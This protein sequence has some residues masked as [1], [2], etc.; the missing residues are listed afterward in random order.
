MILSDGEVRATP[1]ETVWKRY[2]TVLV[3]DGGGKMQ[4][5]EEPKADWARHSYRVLNL[6]DNQ[7]R[8]L[9]QRQ[10][11]DLFQAKPARR[12][13]VTAPIGAFAPTSPITSSPTR[14]HARWTGLKELAAIPT[15]LKRL[16]DTLQE[17][18]INWATRCATP[19][20]AATSNRNFRSRLVSRTP[21]REFEPWR[22]KSRASWY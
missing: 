7:V 13:I 14:C 12:R 20:C 15:R 9:R 17:R 2:G 5:E 22:L 21:L 18:L 19:H 3:S 4:A 8:S 16:D 10:V 11:I 1:A 6:I